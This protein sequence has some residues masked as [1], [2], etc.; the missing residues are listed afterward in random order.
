MFMLLAAAAAGTKKQ[1][2]IF[3]PF[4]SCADNWQNFKMS[5]FWPNFKMSNFLWAVLFRRHSSHWVVFIEV[6]AWPHPIGL[7]FFSDKNPLWAYLLRL[8]ARF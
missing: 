4:F 1:V 2:F 7:L 6:I 3:S 5:K 8:G